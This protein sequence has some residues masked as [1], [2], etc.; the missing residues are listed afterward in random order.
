M[1]KERTIPRGILEIER[2]I[3]RGKVREQMRETTREREWFRATKKN[4][5]IVN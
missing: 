2:V 3:V 5:E 1:K 4:Q